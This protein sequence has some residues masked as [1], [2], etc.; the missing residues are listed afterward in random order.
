LFTIL[1]ELVSAFCLIKVLS[2]VQNVLICLP[3]SFQGGAKVSLKNKCEK[4]RDF[5]QILEYLGILRN[6]NGYIETFGRIFREKIE[7]FRIDF[8][9]I[10][11]DICV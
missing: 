7:N 9:S 8:W 1:G 2:R 5:K 4:N 3:F 6:F 11:R 10:F